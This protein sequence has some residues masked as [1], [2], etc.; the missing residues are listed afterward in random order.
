MLNIVIT[1]RNRDLIL[2]KNCLKSLF[3]QTL[4]EKQHKNTPIFQVFFLDYGS[5]DIFSTEI[6]DFIL[7]LNK[8]FDEKFIHYI[9]YNSKGQFWN[10]SHAFNL[11]FTY[12]QNNIQKN[13][14]SETYFNA[15]YYLLLDVD[16]VLEK[17]VLENLL[18]NIALKKF[19][20]NNVFIL[21]FYRLPKNI[22]PKNALENSELYTKKLKKTLICASGNVFFHEKWL[23]KTNNFDE[24]YRFWGMEDND[25]LKKLETLGANIIFLENEKMPIFHQW[26]PI[27]SQVLPKGWQEIINDYFKKKYEHIF[28]EKTENQKTENQKPI[29][30]ENERI[31]YRIFEQIIAEGF[32]DDFSE[33]KIPKSISNMPVIVLKSPFEKSFLDVGS[34]FFSLKQGESLIFC[35]YTDFFQNTTKTVFQQTFPTKRNFSFLKRIM[36]FFNAFFQK[37]NFSY[38]FIDVLTHE[39]GYLSPTQL[40]D[41]VFYFVL[42]HEDFL[43]DYYFFQEK[44]KFC[45]VIT[46]RKAVFQ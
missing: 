11:A 3:Q 39:L 42:T 13:Y 31:S 46:K 10:K 41:W 22:S 25:F 17:S 1:Y 2:V 23:Q 32:L 14:I 35:G 37:I 15:N 19:E 38:R 26:H 18:E 29:H 16:L 43:L 5:D 27:L 45:F 33:K 4:H 34:T 9:Y 44:E 12:I 6:Q 30:L 21:P 24:F 28:F 7:G 40:R 36:F 8:N 20:E